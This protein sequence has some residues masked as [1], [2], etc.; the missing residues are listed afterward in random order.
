MNQTAPAAAPQLYP[1]TSGQMMIYYTQKFCY[2]KQISNICAVVNIENDVD[3]ALLYQSVL[4]AAMRFPS[5]NCRITN[6]D[7]KLMQ[8]FVDTIPELI[9]TVDLSACSEQEI[10]STIDKWSAVPFPNKGMD[11]PLYRINILKMPGGKFALYFCVCHMIMDAYALMGLTTYI[12]QIYAALRDG[13]AFPVLKKTPMEC[14]MSGFSYFT[15]EKYQKDQA[16]WKELFKTEPTFT[17]MNGTTGRDYVKDKKYGVVLRSWKVTADHLNLRIPKEIVE[18]VNSLAEQY[19]VSPHTV[20]LVAMRAYLSAVC[21]TEDVTFMDTVAR[22]STLVQ[23]HAGGTMVNAIPLRTTFSND[24]S[25][26]DTLVQMFRTQRETYRHADVPCGQILQMIKQ[27]HNPPVGM[28]NH[29]YTSVS[30]TYQPYFIYDES[31]FRCTFQRRKSGA[32]ATPLYLSIMPI[33]NSGDF[34]VNYE[35]LTDLVRRD[36]LEK[37]HAFMLNFVRY[38]FKNPDSTVADL[39]KKSL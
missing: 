29:N 8:Y 27:I 17:S 26:G 24:M 18:M 30:L 22:R 23:K 39:M 4:L 10:D 20:Y 34:W 3:E 37:S 12:S 19:M 13:T 38:G 14:Y 31:A 21:G 7:D 11:V 5:M 32:A 1:I 36:S 28:V 16:W 15:S 2:K 33:D 35:Y 25:L 6:K 9:H